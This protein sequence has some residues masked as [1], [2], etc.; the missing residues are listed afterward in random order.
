MRGVIGLNQMPTYV[1]R[2]TTMVPPPKEPRDAGTPSAWSEV[3]AKLGLTLPDD[4]KQ[5]VALYGTGQWQGFWFMLTPFTENRFLNLWLQSQTGDAG[6]TSKLDAERYIRDSLPDF[7]YP[8]PI[9]PEPGGILP[10][11]STDNGGNFFWLTK[12]PSDGWNTIYYADRSFEFQEYD[13][14]C[15]RLLFGAV[16]GEIP[17]FA[18][19]L[20][21][22][23]EYGRADAF[24]PFRLW[25]DG[26]EPLR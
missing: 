18:E 5:I 9:Y 8:H 13:L 22:D 2:L 19:E 20:G 12:G 6:Q 26:G 23:Y 7:G 1:E 14:S 21:D 10:W 24:V 25:T 4:Y 15:S 11:A 16:S 3:E 17:I